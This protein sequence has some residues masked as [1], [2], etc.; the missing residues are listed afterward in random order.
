MRRQARA[1]ETNV[2]ELNLIEMITTYRS[3]DYSIVSSASTQLTDSDLGF[4]ELS[5][6]SEVRPM[7]L[8]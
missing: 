4:P 2:H 3:G 1:V 5:D 8:R 6:M 7:S